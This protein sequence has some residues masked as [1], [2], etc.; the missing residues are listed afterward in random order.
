MVGCL[1]DGNHLNGR[2]R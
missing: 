1:H 2:R